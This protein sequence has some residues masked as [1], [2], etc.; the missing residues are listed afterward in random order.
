MEPTSAEIREYY[1][2]EQEIWKQLQY[3]KAPSKRHVVLMKV[4]T[5]ASRESY[6]SRPTSILS[7]GCG[8]GLEI[9]MMRKLSPEAGFVG[10]DISEA[11]LIEARRRNPYATFLNH[12]FSFGSELG[13][14][15][16]GLVVMLDVLEHVPMGKRCDFLFNV[17]GVLDDESCLFVGTPKVIFEA[18]KQVVDEP[19]VLGDLMSIL[20]P[21][22][23]E[24]RFFQVLSLWTQED[25]MA[26][27]FKRHR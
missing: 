25:Y 10:V 6:M 4:L 26:A 20:Q 7:I 18:R 27:F 3:Y 2:R 22:G 14:Q 23:L 24:L 1:S 21:E 12:D 11:L 17:C 8:A 13:A 19:V 15:G 16:F 5:A 9:S